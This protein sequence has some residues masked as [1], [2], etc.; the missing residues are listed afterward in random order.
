MRNVILR[1]LALLVISIAI[2]GVALVAQKGATTNQAGEEEP[3]FNCF[4]C[5]AAGC[6]NYPDMSYYIMDNTPPFYGSH[7]NTYGGASFCQ[8]G[9]CPSGGM[10]VPLL[11]SRTNSEVALDRLAAINLKDA[12]ALREFVRSNPAVLVNV[13]RGAIQ[14]ASCDGVRVIASVPLSKTVLKQLTFHASA[15]QI[16]GSLLRR[17]SLTT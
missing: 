6:P 17:P 7:P 4:N 8:V 2:P 11:A 10:C 13:D 3:G 1:S 5:E 14:I 9:G 16:G 15:R 12:N